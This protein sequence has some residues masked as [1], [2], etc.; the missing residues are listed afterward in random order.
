MLQDNF[1]SETVYAIAPPPQPANYD[2]SHSHIASRDTVL[3]GEEYSYTLAVTNRGPVTARNFTLSDTIPALLA[4]EFLQRRPDVRVQVLQD[5][6]F[7]WRFDSLT[8]GAKDSIVF[9]VRVP[10]SLPFSPYRLF[11]RSLVSAVGDTML[12]DNFASATVY[13]IAPPQPRQYD[14]SHTH[15]ASK[16]TVLVGEKYSYTLAVTNRGP[17]TARNFTLSDTLPAL[18][19]PEFLQRRP[20][21]RMQVS[22]DSVFVWRFDSL[23]VGAKDS[24]VFDVRVP[25]SLP[26]SPYRL[27][28]RSLVS[29]VG[30]TM[31]QDNFASATVYAISPQQPASYDLSLVKTANKDTVM[32]GDE[33]V[34]MLTIVNLGP[35]MARDIILWDAVPNLLAASN[36]SHPPDPGLSDADTLVWRFDALAPNASITI[37]FKVKVAGTIPA[38]PFELINISR[39]RS[40]NDFAPDNDSARAAVIAI[41][42]IDCYLDRNVFA[43]DNEPTLGINFELSAS[44][45][46]R[47]DIYDLAGTHIIKLTEQ[48]YF[49]GRHKYE[50]NG[51]AEDGK[52]AG[53][54]LYAV[55]IQTEIFR[56]FLKFI[57]VR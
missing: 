42:G 50:W 57:I 18:L 38:S 49:A 9:D 32:I 4:P 7:V 25:A 10:A 2:L 40:P 14:L 1:A 56:C 31:L 17:V 3:A 33:Y 47:L 39:V 27:F 15:T 48:R 35:D 43:A 53:S 16:D 55:T 11:S 41:G 12:Q 52:R 44:S 19:A 54:G 6:V 13:A 24:I 46:V 26:F 5:S 23:T 45:M 8:V 36:F 34:Y 22:Q 29:A 20:D 21:V 28:S 30:D 51:L 37:S